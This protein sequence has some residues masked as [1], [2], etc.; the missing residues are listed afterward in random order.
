MR[1]R[2]D[3]ARRS[4]LQLVHGRHHECGGPDQ[5]GRGGELTWRPAEPGVLAFD[6]DPG[7]TCVV[8][9]SDGPV[10]LPHG[11]RVLLSSVPLVDGRLP[12][13]AAVWLER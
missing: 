7:F 6:R 8:N 11:A 2:R 12:V 1:G 5:P 13:D 3:R 9:L 10:A 4:H